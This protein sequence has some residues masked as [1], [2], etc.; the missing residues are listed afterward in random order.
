M[1][2]GPKS[3]IICPFHYMETLKH[4]YPR[5]EIIADK[6]CPNSTFYYFSVTGSTRYISVES[7]TVYK[8]FKSND[9]SE[10]FAETKHKVKQK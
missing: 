3:L 9:L 4:K 6:Y 10:Y 8:I 1:R 5:R 7:G 2:K